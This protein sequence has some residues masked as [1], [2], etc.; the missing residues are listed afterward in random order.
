MGIWLSLV[1]LAGTGSGEESPSDGEC[2]QHSSPT[3]TQTPK[4]M[5]GG[6]I[7]QGRYSFSFRFRI[8]TAL[9][10]SLLRPPLLLP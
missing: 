2:V 5:E 6:L 8:P 4:E 9:R 10:L 7:L 3:H 1:R